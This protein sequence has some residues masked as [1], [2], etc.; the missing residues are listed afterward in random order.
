MPRAGHLG[1][2]QIK[3]VAQADR[4]GGDVQFEPLGPTG[5]GDRHNGDQSGPLSV[6]P[7]ERDLVGQRTTKR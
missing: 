1:A 5:A 2:E 6:N 3:I 4:Q 7:R